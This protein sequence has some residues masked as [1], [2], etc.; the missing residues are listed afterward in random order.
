MIDVKELRR[1]DLVLF[2]DR[3]DTSFGFCTG[4]VNKITND[5][6]LLHFS[7]STECVDMMVLIDKEYVFPFPIGHNLALNRIKDMKYIGKETWE[8]KGKKL[9]YR[10]ELQNALWD[11]GVDCWPKG[12]CNEEKEID[13]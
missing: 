13:L 10:H 9:K 12:T 11:D 1:N 5:H 4:I 3:K 7:N 2:S 6:L 8:Y